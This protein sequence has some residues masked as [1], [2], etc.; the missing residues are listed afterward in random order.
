MLAVSWN[1]VCLNHC[2]VAAETVAGLAAAVETVSGAAAVAA[3]VAAALA[4]AAAVAAVAVWP[5]LCCFL[6]CNSNRGLN[7]VAEH[8]F[9]SSNEFIDFLVV[10]ENLKCWH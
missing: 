10:S 8:H 2:C 6:F 1:D 7:G 9:I 5:S 4:A 3:V